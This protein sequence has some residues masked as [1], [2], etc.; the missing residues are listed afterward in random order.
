LRP[1]PTGQ[2]IARVT[3]GPG[4]LPND[5]GQE[6]RDYDITPYTARVTSTNRPEQAVLD[7]ILRETGYEAWHTQPLAILSIDS[8]R[9]SVYHT[10]QMHAVVQELVDRFVNTEAES[11]VF[12]MVVVTVP[13]P[14]WRAKYHQML[15][16]IATQ[17]QGAQA[18]LLAKEDE[19]LMLADLRR[20]SGFQEHSTPHLMVN[21]GQ[22]KT[23]SA[24]QTRNYM[25]DV[26]LKAEAWP[27]YEPQMGQFDE[28]F[29]LE[30]SPL[31]SLDGRVID[32]V[33]RCEIDQIEKMN[34]VMID[35]PTSVAPRQRQKIEVPQPVST[36]LHERF[37]W[38][39]E[40]VLLV[41][42]ALGPTPV[43][44]QGGGIGVPLISGPPRSEM[45]IYVKSKGKLGASPTALQPGQREASNFQGRY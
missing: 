22:S 5:A 18:W 45:L 7:W 44:G 25:R 35:T 41:S 43:P 4:T 39:T 32:A 2:P 38:P 40:Q 17:A 15:R 8:R 31:L 6:W 23:I 11:H 26:A 29:K 28:G 9:L 33:I 16:P 37:R 21:N 27:G 19:A 13:D 1:V 14:S 30:F 10:P 24:V 3:K 12:G 20:R 36:R 42:L 34:A